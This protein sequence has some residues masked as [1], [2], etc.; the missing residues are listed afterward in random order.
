MAS[1]RRPWC[2]SS[3]AARWRSSPNTNLR[4]STEVGLGEVWSFGISHRFG[5]FDRWPRYRW[6]TTTSDN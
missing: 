3:C 1:R 6:S 5:A 4:G 2:F